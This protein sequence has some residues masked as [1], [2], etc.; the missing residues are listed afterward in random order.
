MLPSQLSDT[1]LRTVNGVRHLFALTRD[2]GKEPPPG[3]LGCSKPSGD[4]MQH[5]II[6]VL[7][8]L[9]YCD[10][11]TGIWHDGCNGVEKCSTN[12]ERS[13]DEKKGQSLEDHGWD[14]SV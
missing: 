6:K 13:D 7:S 10:A 1:F 12:D 5:M 14:L 3:A 4:T 8:S 2:W 11:V 9:T